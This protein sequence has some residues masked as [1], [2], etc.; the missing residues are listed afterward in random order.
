VWAYKRNGRGEDPPEVRT[1]KDREDLAQRGYRLLEGIERIPGQK[2]DGTFDEAKLKKWVS[3]VREASAELDRADV[4]DLCLGK[5]FSSAPTGADGVWP[6]EAV[7]DVIEDLQSQSLANGAHT[8]L[9][10]SRGVH[11]RGEGGA[12]ERELAA[13]YRAWAESLQFTHPFLS[14]NLL[15]GMVRTYEHEAEQQDTQAGLQRRLR[16]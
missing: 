3:D 13:K 1:P 7:R 15:M 12:Q 8:A 4:C 6:C 10:N 9:Y 16:I 11:W 14:S 2:D 5:L